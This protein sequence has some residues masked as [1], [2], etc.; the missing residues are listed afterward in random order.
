MAAQ[1]EEGKAE[2]AQ[3]ATPDSGDSLATLKGKE[4]PNMFER[5]P[6]LEYLL[7]TGYITLR[8]EEI[9]DNFSH[10]DSITKGIAVVQTT[11]FI[12]QVIARAAEGLAITELEIITVAFALL[13]FG[14]YFLWWDKPVR[15]RHPVRVYWRQ[16][17][18]SM[19]KG[20]S[21][22][23]WTIEDLFSTIWDGAAAIVKYV[24]VG[25]SPFCGTSKNIFAQ[26]ILLPLQIIW[27]AIVV[28]NRI[29]LDTGIDRNLAIPISSQL[30]DIPPLLHITV[31]VIGTIFGAIH[32]IPWSFQFPTT[33]E[34]LLWR[35]SAVAL[36][37]APMGMGFLHWYWE[38]C[39]GQVSDFLDAVVVIFM[40]A[41]FL[42]NAI[43][44]TTLIVIAFTTL[45]DLPLSAYQTVEWTTLIPHIG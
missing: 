12:F 6:L 41:F 44:R 39:F 16:K 43:F 25:G 11:W 26:I 7:M 35:I 27:H 37:T 5:R 20:A 29:L 28:L 19:I 10:S 45:R 2:I 42:A 22:T 36:A 15:I 33:T 14:T 4:Q 30:E 3:G 31:Y 17:E 13:N 21:H 38:E 24:Y 18:G 23:R 8:E 1:D 40:L 9:K 34:Q 32:C